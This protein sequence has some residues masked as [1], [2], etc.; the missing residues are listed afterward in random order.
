[1]KNPQPKFYLNC[2]FVHEVSTKS[3]KKHIDLVESNAKI[4]LVSTKS[5]QKRVDLVGSNDFY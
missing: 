3:T 2:G 4:E 5:H 1:M